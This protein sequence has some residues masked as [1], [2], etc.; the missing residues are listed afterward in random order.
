M[1]GWDAVVR[2][3]PFGGVSFMLG[4]L[5]IALEQLQPTPNVYSTEIRKKTQSAANTLFL[6]RGGQVRVNK[7]T[8]AEGWGGKCGGTLAKFSVIAPCDHL[9]A[10]VEDE[11]RTTYWERFQAR[12]AVLPRTL[13][14]DVSA[15]GIVECAAGVR[16]SDHDFF[17]ECYL[18]LPVEIALQYRFGRAV[19]RHRVIEVCNLAG[20]KPG[21]SLSFIANF[22]EFAESGEFDWVIFTATKSLR[23]LLERSGVK[24]TQLARAERFRVSN[25]SDWG[26]YYEHDPRVMAVHRDASR[27]YR[28]RSSGEVPVGANA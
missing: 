3:A 4:W 13:I 8:Y 2:L 18:D 15:S 17:S 21:R 5:A 10:L 16:L 20:R 27:A 14:A 19:H 22:I 11:I 7:P 23:A 26:S 25:P 9:R 28:R 6:P 1:T 24:M 12:L